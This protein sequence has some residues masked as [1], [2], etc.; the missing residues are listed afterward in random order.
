MASAIA[1]RPARR[2]VLAR[3]RAGGLGTARILARRTAPDSVL[4]RRQAR[5]S[6]TGPGPRVAP[7]DALLG[8]RRGRAGRVRPFVC[9]RE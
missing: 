1:F 8:K 5:E 2:S 6:A 9:L 4:V 3:A 7:L